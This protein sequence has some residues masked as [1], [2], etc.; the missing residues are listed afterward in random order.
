MRARGGSHTYHG[1]SLEIERK[2]HQGLFFQGSWVWA[3]NL[4]DVDET[5]GVEGGTTLE[6]TYDRLR[7]RGNASFS[8]RHRLVTSLIWEL[9]VGAGKPFLNQRGVANAVLGGWQISASYIAQTGEYMTPSFS[10]SDPSN[11]QT[12]GG[13]PDRIG[14]GKLPSDQQSIDRW[15]DASAFAVPPSGRFGNSGRGI[16][17]GPGRHA[18]HAGLFK[19]FR[20]FGE[21]GA[22]RFQISFT[23]IFNHANFGN[24]ALNIST[25][26]SV[27]TIRSIQTRDFS[28]PRTGLFG[29][30]Y[31]F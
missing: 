14:S 4:T 17:V 6:N 19:S 28:G 18:F 5:G 25:P 26:A 22:L 29:I 3:K 23:N 12:L 21:H 15:F 11:T 7:E 8:P 16:L 24:P 30:R 27:G 9:P 13:V 20:P 1:M 2:W 10:G 31:D